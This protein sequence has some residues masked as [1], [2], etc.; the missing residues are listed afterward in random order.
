MPWGESEDGGLNI[1]IYMCIRVLCFTLD[2]SIL[3]IYILLCG[4]DFFIC[5]LL[6]NA[7]SVK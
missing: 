2:V 7:K 3:F 6:I 5:I 1:H 4:I